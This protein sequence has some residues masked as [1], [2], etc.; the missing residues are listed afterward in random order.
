MRFH[1]V[2]LAAGFLLAGCGQ[3]LPNGPLGFGGFTMTEYFSYDGERTWEFVSEDIL[4]DYILV[5]DLNEESE[6]LEDGFTRV[7]TI[8]YTKDCISTEGGCV[9]DEYVRSMKWSSNDTYGTFLHGYTLAGEEAVVFDPPVQI[10]PP[11]MKREDSVTTETGGSTWTSTLI[12]IE[13]CPVQWAVTW[14]E[15]ARFELDDGDGDLATGSPVSGTFWAITGYNVV[16]M[17]W[18][19]SPGRWELLKHDYAP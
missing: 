16:A 8:D 17:D 15:C 13:E 18:P 5:A 10:T 19:G 9:E 1:C 3:S 6:V 14:D 12:Q 4:I 2:F 11:S 7:Y